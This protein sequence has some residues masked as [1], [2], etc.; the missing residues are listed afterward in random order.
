MDLWSQRCVFEQ[1]SV[2]FNERS[3]LQAKQLFILLLRSYFCVKPALEVDLKLGDV[4]PSTVLS[5]FMENGEW[6][7]HHVE[8]LKHNSLFD[9]RAEEI[10]I[11]KW[12]LGLELSLKF[13]RILI[14]GFLQSKH[15]LNA[16]FSGQRQWVRTSDTSCTRNA[17]SE[18]S[19]ELT[20]RS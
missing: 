11:R 18:F 6:D 16:S 13:R 3:L 20:R 2:E 1:E 7:F 12:H 10:E 17:K 19:N 4:S 14:R 15:E 9:K 5:K 8:G